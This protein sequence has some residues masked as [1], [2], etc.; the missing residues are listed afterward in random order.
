MRVK[1]SVPSVEA[2][3]QSPQ[4]EPDSKIKTSTKPDDV[5][6]SIGDAHLPTPGKSE[7]EDEEA[8]LA[9][10]HYELLPPELPAAHVTSSPKVWKLKGMEL[11]LSALEAT[12]AVKG[13]IF[14]Y[15]DLELCV[16]YLTL[17]PP[18]LP[19]H[20]PSTNSPSPAKTSHPPTNPP[21]PPKAPPIP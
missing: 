15:D 16:P 7:E 19:Q 5:E 10:E 21:P 12:V 8:D 18:F 9:Y 14:T 20:Q 1:H 2:D 4:S 6:A 17:T 3:V 11:H 13:G